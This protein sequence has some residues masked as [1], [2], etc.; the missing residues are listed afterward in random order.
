MTHSNSYK[1]LMKFWNL[2]ACYRNACSELTFSRNARALCAT[3]IR[4]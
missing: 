4:H 2:W 3:L 1:D